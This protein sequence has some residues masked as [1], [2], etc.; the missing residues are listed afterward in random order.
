MSNVPT[1]L[2][3]HNG[4]PFTYLVFGPYGDA[5]DVEIYR[6]HHEYPVE[7]RTFDEYGDVLPDSL[8]IGTVSDVPRST[9]IV[10]DVWDWMDAHV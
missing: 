4:E 2:V 5:F 3:Y 7:D 1:Y 6:G 10:I 8:Y 9:H